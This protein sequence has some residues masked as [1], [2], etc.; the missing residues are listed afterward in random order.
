MQVLFS[1]RHKKLFSSTII[2]V[3]PS[4]KHTEENFWKLCFE[5]DVDKLMD[6]LKGN[7]EP[8]N[9]FNGQ[10]ATSE[11]TINM[12]SFRDIGHQAVCEHQDTT[13]TKLRKCTTS[14]SQVI[15]YVYCKREKEWKKCNEKYILIARWK[16]CNEKK[17]NDRW[18][19]MFFITKSTGWWETN[20]NKS[21]WPNK[22]KYCT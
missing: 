18:N 8:V 6:A 3:T 11:Q 15:N 17:N 12:L 10:V 21:H 13:N 20:Q 4:V 16:K 9:V 19:T 22:L 1:E 2:N 7:W 14:M 5:I